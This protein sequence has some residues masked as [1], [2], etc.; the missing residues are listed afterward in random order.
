M[1]FTLILLCSLQREIVTCR[2]SA[3]QSTMHSTLPPNFAPKFLRGILMSAIIAITM[4]EVL[5]YM[6]VEE[7]VKYGALPWYIGGEYS[8]EGKFAKDVYHLSC[9]WS[10]STFLD[11]NI[12]KKL[13]K[14]WNKILHTFLFPQ[15][16]LVVFTCFHST[17]WHVWQARSGS[18]KWRHAWL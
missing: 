1:V 4:T 8:L 7:Y 17:L 13:K 11:M 2:F 6:Q 14:K 3:G 15:F 5:V 18:T 9:S 16:T 10:W 12:I